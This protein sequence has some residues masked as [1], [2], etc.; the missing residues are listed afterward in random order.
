MNGRIA[1]L[2]ACVAGWSGALPAQERPQDAAYY[3]LNVGARWTY[4]A[5]NQKVVLTLT[6]FEKIGDTVCGLLETRSTG[7][8]L[9]TEHLGVRKDGLYRFKALSFLLDPPV[10]VLKLPP[11]KGATWNLSS[12][13]GAESIQG[14][15]TL[16]EA[17]VTVPHGKHRAVVVKTELLRGDQKFTITTYFARDVGMVKQTQNIG[18][19]ELVLELEEFDKGK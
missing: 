18:G 5:G 3:P 9:I 6:K 14:R 10:C 15:C 17:E 2:V 16:D 4:R 11:M 7:G 12:K 1:A 8:L 19:K 13:M